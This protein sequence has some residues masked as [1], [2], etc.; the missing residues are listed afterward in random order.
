M[1]HRLLLLLA[2]MLLWVAPAVSGQNLSVPD[3]LLDVAWSPDGRWLA[4]VGTKG[5]LHLTDLTSGAVTQIALIDPTLTY[6]K[7]NTVAWSPDS[8][9]F[10]VGG[11]DARLKV[12]DIN[13]LR[14][15]ADLFLPDNGAPMT[16]VQ[17]SGDGSKIVGINS[18]EFS[19]VVIWDA[20]TYQQLARHRGFRWL[21]GN[22]QPAI[23]CDYPPLKM[24]AAQ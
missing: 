11:D 20:S 4:A 2:T 13:T 18:G 12:Y 8:L 1:R 24:N 17:W 5:Q 6:S 16:D 3:V 22:R 21:G 9:Q 7:L 23:F 14:V 10:A 15:L 19:D